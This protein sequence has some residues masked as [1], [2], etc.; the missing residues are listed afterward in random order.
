MGLEI[1]ALLT[2]QDLFN[3]KNEESIVALRERLIGGN[4][5]IENE[6]AIRPG[7]LAY[8]VGRLLNDLE[9]HMSPDAFKDL[10]N[11]LSPELKPL[12]ELENMNMCLS[13]NDRSNSGD[14]I[15]GIMN[16]NPNMSAKEAMEKL[17]EDNES[18]AK[19]NGCSIS[20]NG[21]AYF[22]PTN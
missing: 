21:N 1:E 22:D 5:L 15:L 20:D 6:D 11:N 13:F 12:V 2:K 18:Y 3:G 14:A 16:R 8:A 9:E 10:K 7:Q 4:Y 19:S 17:E